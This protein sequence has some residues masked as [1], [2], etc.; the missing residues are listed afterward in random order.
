MNTIRGIVVWLLPVVVLLAPGCAASRVDF[1]DIQRPPRSSELDAYNVFVGSW[2]W[3]AEMLNAE[4]TDKE[5]HGTAEWHWTLDNRALRGV[6]S[7]QTARTRF[8]A[9]GVWS[10]HPKKKKYIWSMINNWGYPQTG[11]ARFDADAKCWRMSYHSVGLDGTASYGQYSV[12][13]VDNDTLRW[14][15]KEWALP[16]HLVLKMEMKGTYKRQR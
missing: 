2:V 15:M 11:T 3:E 12:T 6:M 10:W 14:H 8:E 9:E 5:W 13:V 1:A 7:S 16:L 4:G